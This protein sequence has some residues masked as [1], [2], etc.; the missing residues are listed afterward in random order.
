MNIFDEALSILKSK[1]K[2]RAL[3]KNV[4]VEDIESVLTRVQAIQ[5]E[6]HEENE[7]KVIFLKSKEDKIKKITEIMKE[8]GISLENLSAALSGRSIMRK[9]RDVKRMTFRYES[10]SGQRVLWEGS[11]AGRIPTEFVGYLKRTGKNRLDCMV[12]S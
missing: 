4:H 6:K 9:R 12:E 7:Q 1:T 5:K 3:F 8:S 10:E 2:L 11:N